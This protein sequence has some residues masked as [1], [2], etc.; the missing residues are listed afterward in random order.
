MMFPRRTNWQTNG[1][2][3]S[4]KNLKNIKMPGAEAF[5][6]A[7][8]Q[9]LPIFPWEKM[10]VRAVMEEKR[11][12][13]WQT[14]EF[15]PAAAATDRDRL[16]PGSQPF[17][18][19]FHGHRLRA[20]RHAVFLP[21]LLAACHSSRA[22]GYRPWNR[23]NGA[24][25]GGSASVPLSVPYPLDPAYS[26]WLPWDRRRLHPVPVFLG[27]GYGA[28][29]SVYLE[30]K[31]DECIKEAGRCSSSATPR[32]LLFYFLNARASGSGGS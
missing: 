1:F 17:H 18:Q 19:G 16:A 8:T 23:Q 32:M 25:H 24:A 29:D 3:R 26:A 6:Q 9:F 21:L 7:Y 31:M 2:R 13:R 27:A 30:G 22:G 11:G 12:N 28:D 20:N 5:M 10:W 15:Q 14:E 4:V